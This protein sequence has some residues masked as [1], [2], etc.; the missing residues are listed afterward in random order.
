MAD[1]IAVAAAADPSL[2][3]P[4]VF[5]VSAVQCISVIGGLIPQLRNVQSQATVAIPLTVIGLSQLLLTA[6][7]T[8]FE[9]RTQWRKLIWQLSFISTIC[10]IVSACLFLDV[11]SVFVVDWSQS[12]TLDFTNPMGMNPSST[13]NPTGITITQTNKKR[14]W[15][16]AIFLSASVSTYEAVAAYRVGAILG[17]RSVKMLILYG[18]AALTCASHVAVSWAVVFY[19]VAYGDAAFDAKSEQFAK[20]T[21]ADLSAGFAVEVV[22]NF[23]FIYHLVQKM[24][25][26]RHVVTKVATSGGMIRLMGTLCLAIVSISMSC[27]IDEHINE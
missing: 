25:F 20:A 21:M 18:I 27:G 17:Q 5:G 12:I 22:M 23:A 8:L 3:V 6:L 14:L 1:Q 24:G 2:L 9:N 26:D 15:A 13:G 19:G 10:A 16:Y 4:S 7:P 11:L